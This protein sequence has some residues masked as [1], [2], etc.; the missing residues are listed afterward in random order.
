M[1][2]TYQLSCTPPPPQVRRP[3]PA[4]TPPCPVSRLSHSLLPASALVVAVRSQIGTLEPSVTPVSGGSTTFSLT[5]HPCPGSS[6]S[7]FLPSIIPH[8]VLRATTS[9]YPLHSIGLPPPSHSTRLSPLPELQYENEMQLDQ[10]R[11]VIQRFY[12]LA[13]THPATPSLTSSSYSHPSSSSASPMRGHHP[14]PLTSALQTRRS[15]TTTLI[16][17]EH[18]HSTCP[19]HQLASITPLILGT[20]YYYPGVGVS[21]YPQLRNAEG[22]L[23]G[24]SCEGGEQPGGY[25]G[26]GDGRSA[27]KR[28]GEDPMNLQ[29]HG[30]NEDE[31]EEHLLHSGGG[32][33]EDP[34][35]VKLEECEGGG[36]VEGGDEFCYEAI[37]A[38]EPSEDQPVTY[39]AFAHPS[40]S[41]SP[42]LPSLKGYLPSLS[43]PSTYDLIH[44]SSGLLPQEME[45]ADASGQDTSANS[46]L[47]VVSEAPE[48]EARP[49]KRRRLSRAAAKAVNG[50]AVLARVIE[51]DPALTVPPARRNTR[52]RRSAR[53]AK[54]EADPTPSSPP[55]SHPYSTGDAA[56]LAGPASAIIPYSFPVL[57]PVTF[58]VRLTHNST[59]P[60]RFWCRDCGKGPSPLT[61]HPPPPHPYPSLTPSLTL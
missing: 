58:D 15:L 33:S 3:Q 11:E 9:P 40:M 41:T 60:K 10:S 18:Q 44:S 19:L 20:P 37:P 17:G 48:G 43:S 25:C 16:N 46:I 23:C 39:A 49:P 31:E 56:S 38:L 6:T 53:P 59:K 28:E 1:S 47:Q 57:P 2:P 4:L 42:P 26:A 52:S 12:Q 14:H 8:D 35:T 21:S 24:G 22:G 36:V 34:V 5:S 30:G 7:P 45:V 32:G 50:V 54:H 29:P 13:S 27:L 61:L 51:M 55:T